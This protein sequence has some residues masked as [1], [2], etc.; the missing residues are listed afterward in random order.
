MIAIM[1]NIFENAVCQRSELS[2]Y[3]QIPI[4]LEFSSHLSNPFNSDYVNKVSNQQMAYG[5]KIE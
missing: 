4:S 3:L 1:N 5:A 2:N